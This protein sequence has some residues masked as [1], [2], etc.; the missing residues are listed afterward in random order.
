MVMRIA[1]S[2]D[3]ADVNQSGDINPMWEGL[4][5]VGYSQTGTSTIQ[6]SVTSAFDDTRNYWQTTG[7]S[8]HWKV[9]MPMA[10]SGNTFWMGVW[11]YKPSGGS[12]AGD[13]FA[14]HRGVTTW[15]SGTTNV[16]AHTVFR[17]AWTGTNNDYQAYDAGNTTV[18]STFVIPEDEWVWIAVEVDSANSGTLTITVNDTDVLSAVAGD[19]LPTTTD[20]LETYAWCIDTCKAGSYWDDFVAGDGSGAQNTG[21]PEKIRIESL[22]PTADDSR[23]GFSDPTWS[24]IDESGQQDG[25]TTHTAAGATND[26]FTCTTEDLPFTPDAILGVQLVT[27]GRKDAEG[28]IIFRPRIKVNGSYYNGDDWYMNIGYHGYSYI[29]EVNPDDSA[30]WEGADVDG[31]LMSG[32]IV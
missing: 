32:I 20:Y 6:N 17:I 31:S 14:I 22:F 11:V 26:E 2:F 19:Y 13:L 25:D 15:E 18:G 16:A 28:E 27:W 23:T 12:T 21:K 3:H 9:L 10:F 30:S 7:G 1:Q 29:W 4:T 5:G 24:V 8:T